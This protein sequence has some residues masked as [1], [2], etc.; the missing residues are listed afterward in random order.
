MA[1]LAFVNTIVPDDQLMETA[2]RM[3]KSIADNGEEAIRIMRTVGEKALDEKFFEMVE[4]AR[5]PEKA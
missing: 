4:S 2:E 1:A 3:A 5:A